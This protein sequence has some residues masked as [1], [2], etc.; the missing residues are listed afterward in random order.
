[1]LGN[2]CINSYPSHQSTKENVDRSGS[3]FELTV[4]KDSEALEF[5]N[6]FHVSDG[7][8]RSRDIAGMAE[9]GAGG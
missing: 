9:H 2:H 3:V 6:M 8:G 1:M 7:R 5:L 4:M